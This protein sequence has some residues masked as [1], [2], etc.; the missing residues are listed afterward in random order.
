MIYSR[1]YL[2]FHKGLI[3]SGH[4][5][6]VFFKK[7]SMHANYK[8]KQW[9]SNMLH[10]RIPQKNHDHCGQ[11]ILH[12]ILCQWIDITKLEVYLRRIMIISDKKS[13]TTSPDIMPS[14]L[15]I[16]DTG[17]KIESLLFTFLKNVG[18]VFIHV[19][20]WYNQINRWVVCSPFFTKLYPNMY[21]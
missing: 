11:K 13:T 15:G 12:G 18:Q 14:P 16:K 5:C 6:Q 1:D 20:E 10:Y 9:P 21:R 7:K 3:V 4:Q 2:P 19:R 8:K 17:I